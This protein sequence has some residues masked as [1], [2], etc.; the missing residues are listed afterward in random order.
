M[1]VSQ[2]FGRFAIPFRVPLLLSPRMA[3][4]TA[5]ETS[6]REGNQCPRMGCF[7]SWNKLK[8]GGLMSGLYGTWCNTSQLYLLSKSVTT[9]PR[10]VRACAVLQN[11]WPI[12]EQVGSVFVHISA[13]FLHPV[14]TVRC[15]H[16]CCTWNSCHD[17][18]SV[19]IDKGHHLLDLW[20]HSSKFFGWG[21]G[22]TSPLVWLWLQLQFK[23]SNPR[24]VNS[25]NSIQECLT[26]NVKSLFQ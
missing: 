13:Q 12:P 19:I 14:T 22:W 21:E 10:C 4:V 26:F 17:D 16:T 20:L 8:S 2:R 18:S 15:C 5:A 6:S 25:D 24:F 9:F 1:T 7:D 3:W 23:V 11:E